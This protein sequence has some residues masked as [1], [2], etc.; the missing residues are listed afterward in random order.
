MLCNCNEHVMHLTCTLHTVHV[1][2]WTLLS[3]GTCISEVWATVCVFLSRGYPTGLVT[4]SPHSTQSLNLYMYCI[5]VTKLTLS[6]EVTWCWVGREFLGV[7]QCVDIYMGLHLQ[8]FVNMVLNLQGLWNAEISLTSEDLLAFEE[9]LCSMSNNSRNIA[10]GNSR[11][12]RVPVSWSC[13]AQVCPAIEF[14]LRCCIP[15]WCTNNK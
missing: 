2:C 14:E 8:A 13:C 1:N 12:C 7:S 5:S 9:D 3:Y 11:Y 4:A 6:F 10:I 15:F